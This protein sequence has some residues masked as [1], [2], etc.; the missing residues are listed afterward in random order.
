[1]RNTL[2]LPATALV[3]ASFVASP[4]DAQKG[5]HK[6]PRLGFQIKPP[7]SW[8]QVPLRPGEEWIVANYQAPRETR[9]YDTE[10]K[11]SWVLTPRMTIYAF[12]DAVINRPDVQDED[13][14]GG[15]SPI[16][17]PRPPHAPERIRF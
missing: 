16:A 1:M 5:L 11:R 12:L 9:V 6:D 13:D 15:F 8:K 17:A 2:L 14:Q 10:S 3:A 4:V 7:K